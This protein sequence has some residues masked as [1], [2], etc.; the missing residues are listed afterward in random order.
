[1]KRCTRGGCKCSANRPA[2][3]S[4]G[5]PASV[6]QQAV[7]AYGGREQVG[8]LQVI[9]LVESGETALETQIVD[10]L[11]DRATRAAKAGRIVDGFRACMEQHPGDD[12]CKPAGET[13]LAGI[14]DR[15]G[16]RGFVSKAGG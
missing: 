6:G 4:S 13:H 2:G 10:E 5:G 7:N 8:G 3:Q 1:G 12:S 14:E 9:A 16:L 11:Y 15:I